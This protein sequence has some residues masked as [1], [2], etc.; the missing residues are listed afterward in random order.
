MEHRG[1][2][3]LRTSLI[4]KDFYDHSPLILVQ[5]RGREVAALDRSQED[6]AGPLGAGCKTFVNEFGVFPYAR[7]REGGGSIYIFIGFGLR[8]LIQGGGSILK[9]SGFGLGVFIV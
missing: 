8:V 1:D 3:V 4:F 2:L 5:L 7:A 9:I 6:D